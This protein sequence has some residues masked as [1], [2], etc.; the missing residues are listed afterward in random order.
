MKSYK[1]CSLATIKILEISTRGGKHGNFRRKLTHFKC[2]SKKKSQGETRKYLEVNET[3]MN[4]W[5]AAKSITQGNFIAVN[6][7]NLKEGTSQISNLNFCLRKLEKY[8]QI[9]SKASRKLRA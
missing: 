4:E 9:E 3:E 7:Y 6:V 2:G 1:T 8:E 5:D